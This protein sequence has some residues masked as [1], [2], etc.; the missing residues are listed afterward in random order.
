M[1]GLMEQVRAF[2]NGLLPGQRRVLLGAVALAIAT[3]IGVG[4]WGWADR[5]QT[6]FESNDAVEVQEVASTLEAQ[7]I[8]H[9]ISGDGRAVRVLPEDTGRARIAA[10]SSG[11]ILGF[12]VLDSI[13]LGT[14]PQRERWTYQRALEGELAISINSL[15]E[16]EGSRVHLVLPERSAF[17]RDDRKPSASV[18][19]RLKAGAVLSKL[20]IRGIT[21]LVSGSVDGMR[22]QDV[23]LVDSEG[24]L[25]SGAADGA[26]TADGVPPLMALRAAEERRTRQAIQDAL[27]RVLGSANDVDIGVTVEVETMALE[28]LTRS[29]DPESQVLISETIREE[30]S[31]TQRPAGIP[32]TQAN[33]PEE[34][35]GGAAQSQQDSLEQR[36]NFAYTE[37]EE[38]EQVAP[39]TVKRVSVGVVVNAERIE[40]I[41]KALVKK[42]APD[43]EPDPAAVTAK[44]QELQQK[45]EETVRVAMGFDK[46]R[47]DSLVVTFLPFSVNAAAEVP[48]EEADNLA[49]AQVWA[50][51]LMVLLALVLVTWFVVRPL[52]G[53]VTR[54]AGPPE[55]PP[56]SVV[57]P[58]A[59]GALT[60]KQAGADGASVGEDGK[61]SRSLTERLRGMVDNFENVDAADLNRLVD[62][63]REA[64]AQVLRRWIREGG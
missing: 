52:V 2:L 13:E 42:A 12:E 50:P 17:L 34:P 36:S 56:L 53:A 61:D 46:A 35:A 58:D 64:T 26:E 8:P 63:E 11:K 9:Q 31:Q 33:L 19:I 3:L 44:E 15:D 22:P 41:A 51:L 54:A 5:Y 14:S 57:V 7:G 40:S 23:V 16:V 37:V 28:R 59:A 21:A 29:Q 39:G 30:S 27:S 55:P 18:T 1:N 20:Q 4:V 48:A 24:N 32:G 6:V 25:L 45:V 47:A 49:Q 43:A 10:A 38:R 60:D 62:L